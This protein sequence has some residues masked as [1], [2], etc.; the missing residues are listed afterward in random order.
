MA[1]RLSG[2]S[3]GLD[4]E[5]IIKELMSVQSLKKTKVE[6]KL[7]KL[8]WKEEKWK[9]LNTKI[10]NLYKTELANIKTQSSY[11]TRS[12]TSSDSTK[13]TFKVSSS[14]PVGTHSL[15]I[16]QVASAQFVTGNKV[17]GVD[18]NDSSKKI[19]ITRATKLTSIKFQTSD[20]TNSNT[21]TIESGTVL[22]LKVGSNDVETY[23]IDDSTTVADLTTWFK[24]YDISF[25]YDTTN[26]RFYM[27]STKSG[28]E[29]AF[30]LSS[31]GTGVLSQNAGVDSLTQSSK[32]LS[33]DSTILS[34]L[35]S[36]IENYS[37]SNETTKNALKVFSYA[38]GTAKDE[39]YKQYIETKF[40]EVLGEAT[41]AKLTWNNGDWTIESANGGSEDTIA[42]YREKLNT[43]DAAYNFDTLMSST[44]EKTADG[45]SYQQ[46]YAETYEAAYIDKKD[47]DMSGYDMEDVFTAAGKAST[48]LNLLGIGEITSRISDSGETVIE[49]KSAAAFIGAKDMVCTYNGNEYTSSS[50]T[51]TINGLTINAIDKTDGDM[52][53][54]VSN[55]TSAVYDMVKSFVSK[56]NEVLGEINELYYA[57]S[58]KGYDVLTDEEREA[59]SDEQIEKWENKIKDSLLRRDST[60][61]SVMSSLRSITSKSVT[62]NGKAYSLSSY[63]INTTDYTEK[64]LLHINGD[65]SDSSVSG[66]TDKLLAALSEDPDTVMEVFTGIANDLYSTLSEKMSST[67]L[68]SAL[69]FYNDKEITS[70]KQDYQE[71]IDKWEDY[72]QDLEDRY[73]SKF[74]AME[75]AMSKLNSQTSYISSLF[76]S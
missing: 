48:A 43:F 16:S 46:V 65:E 75:T 38:N 67:S 3:S 36:A 54:T 42:A 72:L 25:T 1:V 44:T 22:S 30:T 51:L 76:S 63:G 71:E 53:I 68:S 34:D 14:V 47:A 55:D 57:G 39:V 50:N 58:A 18:S 24:K 23:T 37:S 56:Y 31:N 35:N 20:G 11:L 59:M 2:L 69:T 64:G 8:E 40:K 32:Y 45:K 62:V 61:S 10:Y 41:D 6:N 29:N 15:S 49:A 21:G 9:E 52:K 60:L 74:S 12:V 66:E 28:S 17:T 73:Y 26:E 7:T 70:L 33:A 27:S 13:A 19:D 5:S 4:T